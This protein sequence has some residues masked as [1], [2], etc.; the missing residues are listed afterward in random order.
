MP[1]NQILHIKDPNGRV[2]H[3]FDPDKTLS[4]NKAAMERSRKA[5]ERAEKLLKK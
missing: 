5:V 3:S 1:K 4:R 2:I